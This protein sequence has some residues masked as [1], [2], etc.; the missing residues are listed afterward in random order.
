VERT[1]YFFLLSKWLFCVG[2]VLLKSLVDKSFVCHFA[3]QYHI[4]TEK[5]STQKASH[6]FQTLSGVVWGTWVPEK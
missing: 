3:G 1:L 2:I 6:N 5:L 4:L